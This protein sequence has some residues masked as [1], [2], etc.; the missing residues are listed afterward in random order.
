MAAEYTVY[1]V[2]DFIRKTPSGELDI[3]KSLRMVREIVATAG[4]HHDHNILVDL[5]KT[6]PLSNFGD[7]L[8]VATEFAKYQG[9]F[10]DKLAV[11]IPDTPERLEKAKFF[12]A[13]L[14]ETSFKIEYFTDFEKA[15]EWFS[16]IT[17]YPQYRT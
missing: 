8:A 3:D 17:E 4:F 6:V 10:Q 11:I 5:R 13:A 16:E 14:G 12:M 9:I 7:I 2:K 1:N 15:I